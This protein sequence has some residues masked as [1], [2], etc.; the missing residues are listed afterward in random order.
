MT[1][2]K[3]IFIVIYHINLNVAS[4]RFL[5]TTL[6]TTTLTM[7]RSKAKKNSSK[8]GKGPST[9]DPKEDIRSLASGSPKNLGPFA[10]IAAVA[11]VFLAIL[12]RPTQQPN[13]VSNATS[14]TTADVVE[15]LTVETKEFVPVDSPAQE[16]KVVAEPPAEPKPITTVSACLLLSCVLNTMLP[17]T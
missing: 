17:V 5:S 11:V 13:D 10:G 15:N 7:A 4:S 8:R 6:I 14:P 9:K 3:Y 1:H 16:E 2:H 12:F